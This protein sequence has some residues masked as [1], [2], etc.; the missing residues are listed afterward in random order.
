MGPSECSEGRLSFSLSSRFVDGNLTFI[1]HPC[2]IF[3]S[4]KDTSD[5]GLGPP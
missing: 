3:S 5:T 4:Y 2:Q 1:V